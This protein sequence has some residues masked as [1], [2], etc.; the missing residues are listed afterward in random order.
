[1]NSANRLVQN[2]FLSGNASLGRKLAYNHVSYNHR[3][4]EVSLAHDVGP[5]VK[6]V[7]I[8]EHH[9]LFIRRRI[10]AESS[11]DGGQKFDSAILRSTLR[12]RAFF[13]YQCVIVLSLIRGFFNFRLTLYNLLFKSTSS[14]SP[15]LL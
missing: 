1:M 4:P 5:H 14:K 7:I 15:E 6:R 3:S 11:P 10:V 8:Q 12:T 13:E 9:I 2:T